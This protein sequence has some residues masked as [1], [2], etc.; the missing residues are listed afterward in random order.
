MV[1]VGRFEQRV[2]LVN[3]MI[4]RSSEKDG[5]R[6]NEAGRNLNE[7]RTMGNKRW[8]A[9]AAFAL[10]GAATVGAASPAAAASSGAVASAEMWVQPAPDLVWLTGCSARIEWQD[11]KFAVDRFRVVASCTGTTTDLSG[12]APGWTGWKSVSYY[13]GVKK[14]DAD[15]GWTC[16]SE[17]RYDAR[18]PRITRDNLIAVSEWKT[19]YADDE[20]R[21]AMMTCVH[22]ASI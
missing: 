11:R 14:W 13:A 10:V 7:K 19:H 4:T 21:A 16:N 20:E 9:I 17:H 1:I 5:P 22:E 3:L 8:M 15:L 18:T 6:M 12:A 2:E